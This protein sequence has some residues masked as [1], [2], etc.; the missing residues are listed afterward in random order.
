M[1]GRTDPARR[2]GFLHCEVIARQQEPFFR[3][4]SLRKLT[5]RDVA[6]EL[7]LHESTISRA[8]KNKYVQCDRG[9]FPMSALF[10]RDVGQNVGL[11]RSG[12]QEILVRI[13]DREDPRNPL[14]DE[15]I[16]GELE[17]QHI[18]LS[19]RAVAKYRMELGIPAASGRKHA[20]PGKPAAAKPRESL[21]E[22]PV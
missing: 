10:S 1:A 5:L 3:G 19:R 7:E 2:G 13:I 17:K 22:E 6:E 11:S 15:K 18:T 21:E 8:V 12:I 20:M 9:V 16:V 14:S 4:G